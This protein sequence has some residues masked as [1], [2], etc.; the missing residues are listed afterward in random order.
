[1]LT[2]RTVRVTMRVI[3]VMAMAR[4]VF[5]FMIVAV[6]RFLLAFMIITMACFVLMMW[7]VLFLV[8]VAMAFLML[9]THFFSLSSTRCSK[10]TATR[11]RT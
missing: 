1:M 3:V 8:L 4:V 11:L 5:V 2:A 10:P 6:A 9:V 7:L